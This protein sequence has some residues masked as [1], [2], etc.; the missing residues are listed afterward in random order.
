MNF[1]NIII[2]NLFKFS[3]KERNLTPFVGNGTK[4]KKPLKL[5]NLYQK[6]AVLKNK[7][8]EYPRPL[9]P[10]YIF[11]CLIRKGKRRKKLS[12]NDLVVMK[13]KFYLLMPALSCLRENFIEFEST[14]AGIF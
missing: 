5:S 8:Y 11:K 2:N 9:G 1:P 12:L 3:A 13:R 14:I 7:Y 4:V 6:K 10:T